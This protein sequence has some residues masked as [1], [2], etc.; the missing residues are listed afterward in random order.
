MNLENKTLNNFTSTGIKFWLH[1]EQMFSYKEGTGRS[2]VSTHVSP[3]SICNLR[4]SY[5]SVDNRDISKHIKIEVV[6]DYIEKLQSRGLKAVIIT[7]GG[8]P[9]LYKKFNEL[10]QWI[11]YDRGLDVALITNGTCFRLIKPETF[12]AFSWIRMSLN[13]FPDW[14]AKTGVDFLH[15][16]IDSGCVIGASMVVETKD[17]LTTQE[18]EDGVKLLKRIGKVADKIGAEY[19]RLLPNCRLKKDELDIKHNTLDTVIERLEDERFFHQYKNHRVPV[20]KVCHQSYFR[21]YLSEVPYQGSTEP[22]SVYPC[23]SVVLNKNYQHFADEY[24][25]CKPEDILDFMDNK[26][27]F[28]YVDPTKQCN[29]CVFTDTVEMLGK[30][31]RGE[32]DLTDQYKDINIVHKNFI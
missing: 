13:I 10:V 25:I 12:K 19:I 5:C 21:P 8:E 11:K 32:L 23:D 6:K 31:K 4:C 9:T 15:N 1:Q 17:E 7:G 26:G 20:D 14:E 24:Q 2:V 3:E 16:H 27:N 18:V 28:N 29:G 22:G 30:W